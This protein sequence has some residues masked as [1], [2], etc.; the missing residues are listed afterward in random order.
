MPSEEARRRADARVAALRASRQSASR[1]AG[2]N[3]PT[4]RKPKDSFQNSSSR[5]TRAITPR[6]GAGDVTTPGAGVLRSKLE[7]AEARLASAVADREARL[8]E[9]EALR[10]RAWASSVTGSR[11]RDEIEALVR[12]VIAKSE[13]VLREDD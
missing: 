13:K 3:S 5:V 7:A 9:A 2:P 1:D 4:N 11:G 6:R 12:T 8:A 10:R